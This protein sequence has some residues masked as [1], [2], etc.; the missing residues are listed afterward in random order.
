MYQ[1]DLCYITYFRYEQLEQIRS[2]KLKSYPFTIWKLRSCRLVSHKFTL[3]HCI[4]HSI[5]QC[6]RLTMLDVS[7]N[8]LVS[9]PH[10]TALTKLR[11]LRAYDNRIESVAEIERCVSGKLLTHTIKLHYPPNLASE[12]QPAERDGQSATQTCCTGN[13]TS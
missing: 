2:R 5:Q 4:H 3:I 13:V 7:F 6:A 1:E 10:L 12:Q 9:L 8:Q 11:E